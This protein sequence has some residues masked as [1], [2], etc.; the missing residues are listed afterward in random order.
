MIEQYIA[1]D[2]S[3]WQEAYYAAR[4]ILELW[5]AAPGV[6]LPYTPATVAQGVA[7]AVAGQTAVPHE[8]K[9][10]AAGMA[11]DWVNAQ[12]GIV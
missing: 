2:T 10:L 7:R 1:A 11:G 9:S 3:V 8:A 6:R 4:Q 12:R 5:Y